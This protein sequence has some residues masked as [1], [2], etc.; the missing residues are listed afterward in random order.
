MDTPSQQAAMRSQV[1]GRD[2][3]QP[4]VQNLMQA[5]LEDYP[6]L[7]DGADMRNLMDRDYCKNRLGLR[8]QFPL[9]RR[10]AEGR[11]GSETDNR[12]RYYAKKYAGR[13]YVCNYWW[14]AHHR[15]NAESLLQFVNDLIAQKPVHP[16][17]PALE[18]SRKALQEYLG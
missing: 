17:L 4:L 14:K 18:E 12:D 11:K 15:S 5:L 9:L 13:F 16:G 1:R 2:R 7:L 10:I 6:D 3:V 8:I